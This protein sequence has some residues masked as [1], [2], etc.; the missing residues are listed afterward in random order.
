MNC[1]PFKFLAARMVVD[2]DISIAKNRIAKN[3]IEIKD[4]AGM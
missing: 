3:R 2:I 1:H 4:K